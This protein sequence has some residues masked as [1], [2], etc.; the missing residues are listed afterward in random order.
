MYDPRSVVHPNPNPNPNPAEA[1][2]VLSNDSDTRYIPSDR[3]RKLSSP[4]S[5]VTVGNAVKLPPLFDALVTHPPSQV[6]E[7]EVSSLSPAH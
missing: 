7:S 6:C 1:G 4:A 3:T 5:V 2:L